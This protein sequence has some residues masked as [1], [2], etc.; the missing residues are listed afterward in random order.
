MVGI[1]NLIGNYGFPIAAFLLMY[2]MAHKQIKEN[3][4]ILKE[5]KEVV[6]DLKERIRDR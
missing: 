4:D 3:T 2:W 1:E 6:T 5:L